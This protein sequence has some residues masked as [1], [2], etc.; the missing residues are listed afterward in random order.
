MRQERHTQPTTTDRGQG[1][2][3]REARDTAHRWLAR[4]APLLEASDS[5]T[6]DDYHRRLD[7]IDALRRESEA[8]VSGLEAHAQAEDAPLRTTLQ[9]AVGQLD[10]LELDTK[11]RLGALAPG[12]PEGV[13]DLAALRGQL[14]ELAARREL[15][16]DLGTSATPTRL[17]LKLSAGNWAAAGFLGL[18]SFG[19][20]SFTTFHAFMMI[21]G[22]AQA[23]GWGALALL[24]FYGIFWAVG[25]A[26]AWGAIQAAGSETLALAG[27]ELTLRRR[28][29][30]WTRERKAMLAPD[31]RIYVAQ[32]LSTNST[33][34]TTP[35]RELA[36]LDADGHEI[37]FGR[38]CPPHQ[39]EK[40][41]QRLNAYLSGP[42]RD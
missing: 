7:E 18:F 16:E 39:Q 35:T 34:G 13:V 6:S 23:F 19:W 2:L 29:G 27:R 37:R 42:L 30:P 20:L 21:G 36:V 40:F 15:G 12:D 3:L 8:V 24:G 5:L 28:L 17:E 33:P 4:F 38:G 10:G 22:F 25:L 26:M 9:A 31:S 14:A 1:T 41:L 11:R 32:P